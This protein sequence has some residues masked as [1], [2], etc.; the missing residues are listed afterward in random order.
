MSDNR[1]P[2]TNR[3]VSESDFSRVYEKGLRL[4]GGRF[5]FYLLE[6]Q[7]TTPRIGIVTPKYLGNATKRNRIKRIIRENFRKNKEIFEGFDFIVRP[8]ED[9]GNLSNVELGDRFLSDFRA[10][11]KV[12][13]NGD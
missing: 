7:S 1:F 8:K 12:V 13:K 6:S 9:A 10:S 5:V 4:D 2:K 11:K 3:L